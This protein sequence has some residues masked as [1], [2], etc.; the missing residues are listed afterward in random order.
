MLHTQ[1]YR[2]L[3]IGQVSKHTCCT[4]LVPTSI[5]LWYNFDNSTVQLSAPPSPS[6]YNEQSKAFQTL[7]SDKIEGKVRQY[8]KFSIKSLKYEQCHFAHRILLL[9]LV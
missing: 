2:M 3:H 5:S 4:I 8:P 7:Q 1:Y 6:M 9:I